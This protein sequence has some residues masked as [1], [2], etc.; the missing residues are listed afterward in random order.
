MLHKVLATF[1]AKVDS[2][3]VCDSVGYDDLGSGH[4]FGKSGGYHSTVSQSQSKSTSGVCTLLVQAFSD[5]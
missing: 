3:H 2:S 1:R 4:D 5:S